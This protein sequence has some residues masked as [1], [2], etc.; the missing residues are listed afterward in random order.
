MSTITISQVRNM[1]LKINSLD[2]FIDIEGSGGISVPY[3]GY[4]EVNLKIPEIK[5][6]EEDVL[7]MVMNDSRYG[8][9][10]PFAIGTKHTHAALEVMTKKEWAELGESWRCAALPAYT[11]KVSE[12]EHFNLNSV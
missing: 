5:A 7:M 4:V 9:Q 12:M 10:V 6:Y 11:A 8:D 2:Q 1:E 3:I